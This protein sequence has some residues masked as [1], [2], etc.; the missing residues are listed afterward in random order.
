MGVHDGE[1]FPF[2]AAEKRLLEQ[3]L[4]R[5]VPVLGVCLGAQLLA[6][7]LGAP[8]RTADAAE[9]G[10]HRVRLT[11]PAARDPVWSR[12]PEQFHAFHWHGD[13][14]DLPDGAANLARSD[15]TAHQAYRY[16]EA[17]DLHAYG[18]L[19]HLEMTRAILEGMIHAFPDELA[20]AGV[21]PGQLKDESTRWLT[22]LQRIGDGLFRRWARRV[23]TRGAPPRP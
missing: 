20:S 1:R 4:R 11:G 16:G 7:V 21:S 23:R 8:V 14:F 18:I 22:D 2:L 10:W 19:F 6:D 9:I 3:A 5:R 13:V 15:A 12:A 17:G